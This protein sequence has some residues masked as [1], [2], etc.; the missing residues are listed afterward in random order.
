MLYLK[1][2]KGKFFFIFIHYENKTKQKLLTN[3]L[4]LVFKLL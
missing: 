2:N 1:K 3:Y 4:Y